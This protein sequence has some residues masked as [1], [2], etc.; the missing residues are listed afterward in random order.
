M[1]QYTAPTVREK[2][3]AKIATL[4]DEVSSKKFNA[5][6]FKGYH[7]QVYKQKISDK[8]AS[9][10]V[11]KLTRALITKSPQKFSYKMHE[12]W[13]EFLLNGRGQINKIVKTKKS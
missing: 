4:L 13:H 7:P 8:E 3:L 9:K 2:E 6:N 5:H 1:P 12:W 11:T 10:M